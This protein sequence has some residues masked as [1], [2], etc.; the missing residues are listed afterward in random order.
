MGRAF[1]QQRV[2]RKGLRKGQEPLAGE[3]MLCV[4]S[5]FSVEELGNCALTNPLQAKQS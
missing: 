2:A 5:M 3:F 1:G 4:S